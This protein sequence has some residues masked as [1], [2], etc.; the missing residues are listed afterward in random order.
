MPDVFAMCHVVCLPTGYGEGVP[1]ALIEAAACGRPIVA[2]DIA[3]CREIVGDGDN[4]LLVPAAD[5][6]AL[7]GALRRLLED[8]DLRRR[9]GQRG[10]EIAQQGFDEETMAGAIVA[11]YDALRGAAARPA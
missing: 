10:R 1:K 4:G 9:M 11:L 3:G 5:A 6:D 2:T 7:A 8:D